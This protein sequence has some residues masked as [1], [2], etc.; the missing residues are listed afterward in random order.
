MIKKL[1]TDYLITTKGTNGK[2]LEITAYV[3][4]E[5]ITLF[6]KDHQLDFTFIES[7]PEILKGIAKLMLEAVKQYEKDYEI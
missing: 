6:R 1:G 4:D 7:K 5:G 2:T 3:S